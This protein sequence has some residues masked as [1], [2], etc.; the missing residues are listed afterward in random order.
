[1]NTTK[2]PLATENS[3]AEAKARS[4]IL[5]KQ[6]R[7]APPASTVAAPIFSDFEGL[8]DPEV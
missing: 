2:A 8:S 1:M 6:S 4:M 5:K 7:N 3:I